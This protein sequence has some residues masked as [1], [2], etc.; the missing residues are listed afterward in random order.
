M[1]ETAQQKPKSSTLKWVLVGAGYLCL[2]TFMAWASIDKAIDMS[3][4]MGVYQIDKTREFLGD[5]KAQEMQEFYDK[6]THSAEGSPID[7]APKDTPKQ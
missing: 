1:T 5:E 3:K 6:R 4:E 2:I 7:S